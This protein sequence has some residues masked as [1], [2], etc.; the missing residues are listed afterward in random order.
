MKLFKWLQVK[1]FG[2]DIYPII[3]WFKRKLKK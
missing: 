3:K 1:I 2:I